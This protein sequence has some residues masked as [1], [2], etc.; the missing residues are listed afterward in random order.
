MLLERMQNPEIERDLLERAARHEADEGALRQPV[1][2]P[3]DGKPAGGVGG[4][5]ASIERDEQGGEP[6]LLEGAQQVLPVPVTP[7]TEQDDARVRRRP[8]RHRLR[9]RSAP[10]RRC[11]YGPPG[12]SVRI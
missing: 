3:R 7:V 1:A 10:A 8:V 11:R 12:S 5:G 4:E 9:Q 2:E 6:A